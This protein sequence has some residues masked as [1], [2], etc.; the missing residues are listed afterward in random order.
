MTRRILVIDTSATQANGVAR[1]YG[2][3]DSVYI[4]DIYNPSISPKDHDARFGIKSE[5]TIGEFDNDDSY[6]SKVRHNV[7][8]AISSFNPEFV[9]YI[10]GYDVMDGDKKGKMTISESAV[11]MRDEIVF[12]AVKDVQDIPILMTIG[13]CYKSGQ[14]VVISRTIRNLVVKFELSQKLLDIAS[15]QNV[16]LN[17][18]IAKAGGFGGRGDGQNTIRS[19][20]LG[21]MM[22]GA[23]GNRAGAL[24]AARPGTRVYGGARTETGVPEHIK[25]ENEELE[26]LADG[27]F[28]KQELGINDRWMQRRK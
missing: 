20:N 22:A 17:Y 21:G 28:D 13:G 5:V 3:D 18:K 1:D 26:K 4:L 24:G 15:T 27:L 9:I 11:L 8:L 7:S 14:E 10:A 25:Q 2:H 6:L 19:G 16:K 23:G 12:R